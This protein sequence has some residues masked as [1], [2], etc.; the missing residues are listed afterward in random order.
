MDVPK[1][2]KKDPFSLFQSKTSIFH[3]EETSFTPFPSAKK[4]RTVWLQS[5]KSKPPSSETK[6]TTDKQTKN[7][8]HRYAKSQNSKNSKIQFN[9]H[10]DKLSSGAAHCDKCMLI[11]ARCVYTLAGMASCWTQNVLAA[12]T[13]NAEE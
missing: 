10:I 8:T 6:K 1:I 2:T 12:P 9:A 11:V 3:D 7:Q 13:V 4:A 5:P